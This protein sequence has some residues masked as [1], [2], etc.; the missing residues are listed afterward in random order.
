MQSDTN[1][2]GSTSLPQPLQLATSSFEA[3]AAR[4]GRTLPPRRKGSNSIAS[5]GKLG[6][7]TAGSSSVMRVYLCW[8]E[9]SG[10]S[11]ARVERCRVVEPNPARR[12][13]RLNLFAATTCRFSLHSARFLAWVQTLANTFLLL[14]ACRTRPPQAVSLS[15]SVITLE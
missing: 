14:F 12:K 13:F 2:K 4:L 6:G 15:L 7:C 8:N 9:L 11:V 10:A 5:F 1:A 3:N